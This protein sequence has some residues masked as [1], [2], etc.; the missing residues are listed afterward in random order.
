VFFCDC[1]FIFI[2]P[3][4][5]GGVGGLVFVLVVSFFLGWVFVLRGGSFNGV[6][7]LGLIF[8]FLVLA[9]AVPFIYGACL[10]FMKGLA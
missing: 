6:G 5:F 10:I 3:P 8:R 7:P 4:A 1:L 2:F 9:L